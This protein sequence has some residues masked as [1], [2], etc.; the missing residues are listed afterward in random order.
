MLTP[1]ELAMQPIF[2]HVPSPAT[3]LVTLLPLGILLLRSDIFCL[4]FIIIVV[5]F[6]TFWSFILCPF[7]R[8]LGRHC[9]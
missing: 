9:L 1:H 6:P 4:I 8:Y 7:A 3:V 5:G 2:L